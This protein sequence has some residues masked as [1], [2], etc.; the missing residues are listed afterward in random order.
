MRNLLLRTTFLPF[1]FLSLIFFLVFLTGIKVLLKGNDLE[2]KNGGIMNLFGFKTKN[3]GNLSNNVN[4]V[5]KKNRKIVL[6]VGVLTKLSMLG[7]RDVI[8]F[9]WFRQCKQNPDIVQCNFFTDTSSNTTEMS[10]YERE[11][12]AHGD[13]LFMPIKGNH[14][15]DSYL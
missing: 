3:G 2:S 8:R 1:L 5:R 9:T 4:I 12:D 6:V 7:R 13:I 11:N 10:F 15:F 14:I